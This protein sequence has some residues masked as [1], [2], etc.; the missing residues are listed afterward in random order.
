MAGGVIGV[1]MVIWLWAGSSSE[2]QFKEKAAPPVPGRPGRPGR[3]GPAAPGQSFPNTFWFASFSPD[4]R[5]VA[6][7]GG[8]QESAG[9]LVVWDLPG[10]KSK[11]Q[12]D[13]AK[14]IRSLAFSPDGKTLALAL[15]DGK[16]KL[17]DSATGKEQQ[18]LPGHANGVNCVAFSP[19]GL[20]LASASLDQTAKLWD[21]K[22]G[23]EK[24]TFRGHTEYV[25]CVAFSPD[26]QTL[27]TCS[28]TSTHPQTG[29]NAKL[30]DLT[31]GKERATMDSPQT[32]MEF[33]AFSP[34]GR[35]VATVSW[36]GNVKLWD[37][38]TG[39][40][41]STFAAHV[42]G[43]FGVQFSPDGKTLATCG[44]ANGAGGEVK[45]S[46]AATGRE[47]I[48]FTYPSN[49]W[50]A[51]FSPDGR[52]LAVACWDSTVKLWEFATHKERAVLSMT[53]AGG[54]ATG[55]QS[56]A[57]AA[58]LS[59]EQLQ[60]WWTELGGSDAGRAYRAMWSLAEGGKPATQLIQDQIP[61]LLEE[62]NSSVD[63]ARVT[64]LIAQLDDDDVGVREKATEELKGLGKSAEPAM[65]Q[66]LEKT[67]SPEVDYRL[68]LLLNH[69]SGD[70]PRAVHLIRAIEVLENQG[71]PE[72]RKVL[73]QLAGEQ[74]KNP[75]KNEAKAS[76]ERLARRGSK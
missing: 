59:P 29:G 57:G 65:R 24:M 5:T 26:G 68:K 18:T 47:I 8:S 28:G 51:Q 21:V 43:G 45:V 16:I 42:Q 69:S 40:A 2:A 55:N 36:D 50:S 74:T 30:W 9:K 10:N 67:P 52:T 44:G 25:L 60:T 7:V 20:T 71:S 39:T 27:G 1:L 34:D 53:A 63:L 35:A 13:E 61:V 62:K 12:H 76:L 17:L 41:I 49:V 33:L 73:E 58:N 23:K 72:A 75:I 48:A 19:D 64:K 66:A 37:A 56:A 14:G 54:K 11:Y 46:D 3:P 32:P 38:K 6:A 4:G 31:T 70:T 22:T 15:Y